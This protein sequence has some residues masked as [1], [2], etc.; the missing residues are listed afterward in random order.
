MIVFNGSQSSRYDEF[1]NFRPSPIEL[2]SITYPTVEHAFQAQ[3]TVDRIMRKHIAGLKTPGM[4]KKAG[5][6]V[7]LRDDWEDSKYEIMVECLRLKFAQEPF[8]KLLLDT[9]E[10]EIA[11]DAS[12]WNDTEWGLGRSGKGKNKLGLA[13]MQ[14]RKEIQ[15]GT[16]ECNGK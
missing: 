2:D 16:R 11:E 7:L 4:A 15:T 14:V 13:L 9:G 1:S 10:E 12:R 6:S 5:R 3:K 8:K